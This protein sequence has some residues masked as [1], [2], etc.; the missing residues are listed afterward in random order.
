MAPS[1]D[2]L[3]DW[4][5]SLN[6]ESL[7]L[8]AEFMD[9]HPFNLNH[10]PSLTSHG[11]VLE[12]A[13]IASEEFGFEMIEELFPGG[14]IIARLRFSKSPSKTH[15]P[16]FPYLETRTVN[17]RNYLPKEL[18][19]EIREQLIQTAQDSGFGQLFLADKLPA[20]K[21]AARAAFCGSQIM[22]EHRGVHQSL[23]QNIRWNLAD[24]EK[25]RDGLYI[26]TL[27][28]GIQEPA[29]RLLRS[30]RLTSILNFLGLS[31]FAAFQDYQLSMGSSALGLIE[32]PDDSP[33]S[34]LNG[35]K[36]FERLWLKM[37]SLGL[38]LQPESA[39]V[40][41][42]HLFW[43]QPNHFTPSQRRV[44]EKGAQALKEAF[45]IKNDKG[46]LMF[47]RLGYASKAPSA[48]SL[49]KLVQL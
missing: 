15:H 6:G 5:F 14:D 28:L 2:N 26:K 34:I 47:F 37:T 25:T 23:F 30:W 41:F 29:F 39:L 20:K 36:L 22:M 49:R 11:T 7:E 9:H 44:L 35:G 27:E 12:N 1:G 16:L 3:Q 40:Y 8:L 32:V 31:L 38:S 19:P 21:C 46:I 24:A 43:N 4:R 48:K 45:P 33:E 18:P 17:R 42:L 13:R 10:R